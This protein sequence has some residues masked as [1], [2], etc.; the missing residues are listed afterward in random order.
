MFLV[1]GILV[2]L[3]PVLPGIYSSW[4]FWLT[5]GSGVTLSG[6]VRTYREVSCA[7]NGYIS[8]NVSRTKS[9]DDLA[10][11]FCYAQRN[12]PPKDVRH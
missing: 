7:Q 1:P 3:Q 5:Y 9:Y 2:L 11:L 12:S 8:Y 6:V 4:T 10:R